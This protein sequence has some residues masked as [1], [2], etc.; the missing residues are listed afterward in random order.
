MTDEPQVPEMV[1][2]SIFRQ[3]IVERRCSEL[4]R[5]TVDIKTGEL[6]L[7]LAEEVEVWAKRTSR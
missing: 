4:Y 1:A 2:R 3:A 6:I 5:T 7:V